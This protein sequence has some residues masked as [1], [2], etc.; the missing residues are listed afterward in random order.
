[1]DAAESYQ[2]EFSSFFACD[3]HKAPVSIPKR[4][5]RT[6]ARIKR[7]KLFMPNGLD[8]RNKLSNFVVGKSN[9]RA[10]NIAQSIVLNP[11]TEYSFFV[12]VAPSGLGKSHLMQG[13]IHGLM[14][15]RPEVNYHYYNGGEFRELLLNQKLNLNRVK[16]LFVDDFDEILSSDK[17]QQEFCIIFDL[18]K[19]R[20]IQLVISMSVLPKNISTSLPRFIGRISSGAI[21]KMDV[22]DRE[23]GE[24]ITRRKLKEIGLELREDIITLIADSFRFHIYGIESALLKL[25]SYYDTYGEELVFETAIK[26]LQ[27]LGQLIDSGDRSRR[28]IERVAEFYKRDPFE[29]YGPL[30]RKEIAFVRHVAMYVLKEK[31]GLSYKR[32]GVMFNRD[33]S[34]V[35]YAI[36][37]ISKRVSCDSE[38][39]KVVHQLS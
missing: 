20:N 7:R 3:E 27:S 4:N 6:S 37:K 8:G 25:K 18:I 14:K 23:L 1:M 29:L 38:F 5:C 24:S 17:A 36:T 26:E 32:I 10:Y 28:I 33:H 2:L 34:S 30:R 22:L 9:L 15:Y 21:Q 13:M 12:L 19:R 16:A 39:Q 31:A 35:I 11:S